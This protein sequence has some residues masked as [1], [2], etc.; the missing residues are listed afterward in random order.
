[1]AASDPLF[2]SSSS[3]PVAAVPCPRPRSPQ[4]LTRPPL[5]HRLSLWSSPGSPPLPP[6]VCLHRP[7]CACLHFTLASGPRVLPLQGRVAISLLALSSLSRPVTVL[8]PLI[9]SVPALHPGRCSPPHAAAA[10]CLPGALPSRVSHLLLW[11]FLRWFLA[12]PILSLNPPCD[13]G[14]PFL[15]C[16]GFL[17]ADDSRHLVRTVHTPL[18]EAAWLS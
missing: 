15:F 7:P 4:P 5:R 12:S 1:M 2:L 13:S 3:I 14:G 16:S 9:G 18:T 6:S 8:R 17:P 11:T 10:L